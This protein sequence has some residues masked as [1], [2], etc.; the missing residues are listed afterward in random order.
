[1]A[2]AASGGLE[3]ALTHLEGPALAQVRSAL[4]DEIARWEARAREDPAARRVR[5]L[6]V[7]L[8]EA[9]S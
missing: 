1:L 9:L 4:R 3:L 7:A 6:F 5:D 2:R 8:L